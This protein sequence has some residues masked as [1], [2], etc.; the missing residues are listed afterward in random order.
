MLVTNFRTTT[1]QSDTIFSADFIF[2][3]PFDGRKDMRFFQ[4][5]SLIKKL[6]K[7][8]EFF[9][10]GMNVKYTIWFK[11]PTSTA[12]AET[13]QDA[14]FTVALPLALEL[15]ENL[16]FMGQVSAAI[17]QKNQAMKQ[18]FEL[19]VSQSKITTLSIASSGQHGHKKNNAF[20]Q[21]FTLGVD[22]FYTLLCHK[23]DIK[24][25]L[26]FVDGYDIPL[27]KIN[28]LKVVHRHIAA[29]AKDTDQSTIF[30]QSNLRE[31]TDKIIS[32]GRY[33]VAALAAVGMLLRFKQ[34]LI[35]GETFEAADWG[36]R[37]GAD[38]LFS[39]PWLK[40]KFIAHNTTR[41]RKITA[42][43]KSP[44][45]KLFL[46][47]LRSCWINIEKKSGEIQLL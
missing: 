24:R 37:F 26:V 14:F 18:Y 9:Y 28:F 1:R 21:F 41:D 43:K 22:S 36:L 38:K 29:V 8:T 31:V 17:L 34:V 12:D 45:F 42:L 4:L 27:K 32:W 13:M 47:H 2:A 10:E 6:C 46:H 23:P 19:P 30:I 16:Q 25:S 44:K 20:A 40:F 15:R 7:P 33:H 35:S 11:V 5:K 39:L 3:R